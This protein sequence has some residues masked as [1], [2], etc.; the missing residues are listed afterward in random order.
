MVVVYPIGVPFLY[1]FLLYRRRHDLDGGQTEKEKSMSDESALKMAL[2][3]RKNKEEEDPTLKALSF[4]YGSYEPKFWWFEVF[5]TLRK[6]ALTGFLVFLAPGTAAQVLFSLVMSFFAMRVYSDRQPFISESTDSF[7]NAA[8][9]QLF[10]TLLGALALKV[11]LDEENLQNKGYFDLVLTCVQFVP[12]MISSL[13]NAVKARNAAREGSVLLMSGAASSWRGGRNESETGLDMRQVELGGEG[14][15]ELAK[16]IEREKRSLSK[17]ATDLGGEITSKHEK[18]RQ[19]DVKRKK[20][21]EIFKG[22]A[23]RPMERTEQE[24]VFNPAMAASRVERQAQHHY[25]QRSP[26]QAQ[27]LDVW[28]EKWDETNSQTYYCNTVTGESVWEKPVVKGG[29]GGGGGGD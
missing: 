13:V 18:E 16:I 7:N 15:V 26:Q 2:E 6:L 29:G 5:E 22:K 28:E 21:L 12:A 17:E 3:E 20:N 9:L 14:G 19:R 10:F 27:T 11:N 24:R 4:L 8:Q 23:S 1:W 25:Q